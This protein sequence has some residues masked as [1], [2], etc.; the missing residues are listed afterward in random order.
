MTMGLLIFSSVMTS[1]PLIWF[2]GAAKRLNMATVGIMQY[3]NPFDTVCDRCV[4]P[5]GNYFDEQ[6]GDIL[7][8]MA[9]GGGLFL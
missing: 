7:S 1:M 2:S 6:A 9:F 3:I 4:Y 8:D 5:Q